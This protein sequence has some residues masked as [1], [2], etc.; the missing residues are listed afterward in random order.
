MRTFWENSIAHTIHT[1]I[2]DGAMTTVDIKQRSI[3]THSQT[4]QRNQTRATNGWIHGAAATTA[5]T[6]TTLSGRA[7]RI[8]LHLLEHALHVFQHILW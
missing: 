7:S 3:D 8:L 4:H 6:R 2:L 1:R 5:A